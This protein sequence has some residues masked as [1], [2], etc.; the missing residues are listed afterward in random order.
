MLIYFP[1]PPVVLSNGLRPLQIVQ[2]G[3]EFRIICPIEGDP[4]P[5]ID[6]YKVIKCIIYLSC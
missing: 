3:Q 4:T 6:W 5:I 1:G 2:L